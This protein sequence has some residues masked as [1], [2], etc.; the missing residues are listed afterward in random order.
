MKDHESLS[1]HN[2]KE[3]LTVHLVIKTNSRPSDTGG[4]NA[5]AN[6]TRPPGKL[7]MMSESLQTTSWKYFVQ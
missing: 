1:T 4:G 5:N 3:G 2:I 6:T 7:H